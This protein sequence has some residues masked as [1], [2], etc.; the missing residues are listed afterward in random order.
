[1][2]KR[3]L[4]LLG[5]ALLSSCT[6]PEITVSVSGSGPHPT[7]TL[8]QDWGIIFRDRKVPCV[9]D[10]SLL[11]N[12]DWRARPLWRME[13]VRTVQCIDLESFTIGVAPAGFRDTV[14]L[15]ALP[16]GRYQIVVFGIGIADAPINL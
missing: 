8:S 4:V 9:H 2:N 7:V 6:P 16:H 10:V 3:S 15:S 11:P 5:A 14:P 1:M 12:G 13:P